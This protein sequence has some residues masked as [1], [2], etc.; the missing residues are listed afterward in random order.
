MGKGT[1]KPESLSLV[2]EPHMIKRELTPASYTLN[3][4]FIHDNTHTHTGAGGGEVRG[5][6]GRGGLD[7][8][9]K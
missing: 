8:L 5:E 1:A 3:P 6:V 7:I 2:P 9:N 4:I